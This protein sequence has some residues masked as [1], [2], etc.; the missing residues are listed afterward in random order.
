MTTPA[1]QA[2]E[3]D[4][5]AQIVCVR[6]EIQYRRYVYPKRIAAGKMRPVDAEKEVACMEAVLATLS[7]L[8]TE[9]DKRN[10]PTLFDRITP[11]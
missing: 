5:R 6:R 4:L 7:K 2:S 3:F 9:D 8:L 11:Q 1:Y 10:N